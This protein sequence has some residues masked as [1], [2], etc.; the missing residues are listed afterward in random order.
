MNLGELVG[1]EL[2]EDFSIWDFS[3]ITQV[4]GQL[5]REEAIDIAHAERLQQQALRGADIVS[6]YLSKMVKTVSYL[7]FKFNSVK[8]KAG[9]EFKN[10]EEKGKVSADLRKM[11]AESAPEVDEVAKS[12]ARAKGA[13]SALEKKYDLLIK[14][15][16]FY[17]EICLAYRKSIP[18][19]NSRTGSS[20]WE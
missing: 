2:I 5:Q 9:L 15:H 7:E 16:Y 6:E 20:G 18:T 19:E 13:K 1:S 10:P 12:L 4:L 17:K 8:N 11:A 14:S 3:E